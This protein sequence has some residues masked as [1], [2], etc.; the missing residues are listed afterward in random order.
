MG[1]AVE[2]LDLGGPGLLYV[3]YPELSRFWPRYRDCGGKPLA[4]KL[5]QLLKGETRS[6][7]FLADYSLARLKENTIVANSDWTGSLFERTYGVKAQTLYPPVPVAVGNAREAGGP[8][9][10]SLRADSVPG[11]VW[12]G[13]SRR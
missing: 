13:L 2:E 11:S 4:A 1:A 6:W 9:G 12:I 7:M 3:H 5:L 10:S 8:T